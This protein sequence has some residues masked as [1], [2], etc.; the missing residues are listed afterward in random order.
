VQHQADQEIKGDVMASVLFAKLRRWIRRLL[1]TSAVDPRVAIGL[2]TYGVG[3]QT[4]LLFRDDDRVVI[5]KYCSVAYGVTI[6]AS[7][8]HNYRGVANFPFAAVLKGNVD[9]DTFS[10][11]PV[12]V[13]NDVWIGANATILSGVT[14]GD[15]A[16]VAA[17]S[18]VTESVPPYAI[19]GGVPAKIIKYRFPVETIERLIQLG[20]WN[21]RP[22]IIEQNMS[23]F[24]LPVDQFLSGAE[25]VEKNQ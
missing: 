3:E 9:Q 14:I 1:G 13:G 23:L 7:G 18:V 2:G 25:A 24:Y 22:E 19:V 17:G 15:G 4:V 5:G 21:W 10:K 6:V 20:W 12:R 16:V 11:G 8:E